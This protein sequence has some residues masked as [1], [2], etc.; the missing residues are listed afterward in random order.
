MTVPMAQRAQ[1]PTAHVSSSLCSFLYT[2][3]M[4]QILFLGSSGMSCF[5]APAASEGCLPGCCGGGCG[6]CSDGASCTTSNGACKQPTLW[7]L[8]KV[9]FRSF[10]ALLFRLVRFVVLQ[11]SPGLPAGMLWRHM[12]CVVARQFSVYFLLTV[13][14][15][16]GC[17]DGVPCGIANGACP[18]NGSCGSA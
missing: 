9:H 18:D 5:I 11:P 10:L 1:S 2:V 16:G 4:Q 14:K 8:G 7:L 15:S 17:P 3:L 13:L 12:R 6:E